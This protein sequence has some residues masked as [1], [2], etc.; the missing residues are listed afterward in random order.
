MAKSAE[1]VL[2]EMPS[3]EDLLN[4]LALEIGLDL[5]EPVKEET[6]KME[7]EVGKDGPKTEVD[8]KPPK[9]R[10]RPS[11]KQTSAKTKSSTKEGRKIVESAEVKS[12]GTDNA[13]DSKSST[14]KPKSTG[15]KTT[16]KKASEGKKETKKALS[17]DRNEPFSEWHGFKVNYMGKPMDEEG[18]FVTL[19]KRYNSK[20]QEKFRD[21]NGRMVLVVHKNKDGK[22]T[23]VQ[24]V[25]ETPEGKREEM[26]VA[27][28]MTNPHRMEN[29][30]RAYAQLLDLAYNRK[31]DIE[32][33]GA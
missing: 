13:K 9:K 19:K 21:K 27:T 1:E 6:V 8:S 16:T 30:C 15:K 29:R 12:S 14:D 20:A 7:V 33:L 18:K 4:S 22:V 23:K 32:E 26:P 5:S 25:K 11:K 3:G 10:G 17:F 2:N 31:T 28:T 24:V